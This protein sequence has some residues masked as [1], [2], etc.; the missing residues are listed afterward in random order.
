MTQIGGPFADG[1]GAFGG[2]VGDIYFFGLVAPALG[3]KVLAASWTGGNEAI[4]AALSVVGAS[5]VGGTTT[6][7]N[8]AGNNNGGVASDPATITVATA[9]SSEITMAAF[10]GDNGFATA[11][12]TD[13]GHN[14]GGSLYA[15]A[16]DWAAGAA[17]TLTYTR[18]SAQVWE[19]AAVAIKAA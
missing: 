10:M 3:A 18:G 4:V 1:T 8:V 9:L 13:I 14:N 2:N 11:G 15:V 17:P 19:A 7:H 16:A 12:N 6:F 5:Q